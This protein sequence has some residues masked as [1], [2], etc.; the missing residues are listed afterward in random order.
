MRPVG[1]LHGMERLSHCLVGHRTSHGLFPVTCHITINMTVTVKPKM[2]NASNQ[3][4]EH[5]TDVQI[6]FLMEK[7]MFLKFLLISVPGVMVLRHSLQVVFSL[8]FA[9]DFTI[10]KMK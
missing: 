1:G 3:K 7:V 9:V 5:F 2:T 8:E 4:K 10:N 6:I